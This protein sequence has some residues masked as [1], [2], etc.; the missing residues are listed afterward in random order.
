L[1]PKGLPWP[2]EAPGEGADLLRKML[3]GFFPQIGTTVARAHVRETF[4]EFDEGLIG[5][6]DLDWLLRI[7][8]RHKLGYVAIPCLLFRGRPDG[9][10]DS[11][12]LR[13]AGYDRKVFF[14]HAIPEWRIWSSPRDFMRAYA[15]TL[16][17]FYQY[18]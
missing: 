11:L 15:G 5:G 3:S 7:S 9:T 14:R 18:L 1:V 13:R 10:Y 16:M 8:R 2:Q 17:H 6:Q 4:G 12:Q